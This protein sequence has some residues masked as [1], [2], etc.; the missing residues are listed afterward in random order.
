MDVTTGTDPTSPSACEA[1][2]EAFSYEHVEMPAQRRPHAMSA[3]CAGRLEHAEALA[4]A[5]R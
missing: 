3:M 1:L 4:L 5:A 2:I